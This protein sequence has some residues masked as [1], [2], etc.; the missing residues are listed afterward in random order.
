LDWI[1]SGVHCGI[2]DMNQNPVQYI[3][4]QKIKNIQESEWFYKEYNNLLSLENK[5]S[6]R[7]LH[8]F[9]TAIKNV[10]NRKKLLKQ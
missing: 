6:T 8:R 7:I 2:S 3:Q 1:N 5:S 9:K 4:I 10:F